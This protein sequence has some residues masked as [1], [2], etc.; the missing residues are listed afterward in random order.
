[1]TRFSLGLTVTD[2]V[3]SISTHDPELCPQRFDFVHQLERQRRTGKIDAKIALQPQC[4]RRATHVR[5]TEAPS[6][7]LSP[8]GHYDAFLNQ[9]DNAIDAHRAGAADLGQ[10][11]LSQFLKDKSA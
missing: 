10:G 2:A 5:P 1:M 3:L 6:M 4:H 8:N 7:R 9:F 11:Q